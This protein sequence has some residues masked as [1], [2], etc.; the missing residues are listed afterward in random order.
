MK[1]ILSFVLLLSLLFSM[2]GS[3]FAEECTHEEVS[4]STY[5][6]TSDFVFLDE[7][8]HEMYGYEYAYDRCIACGLEM[9]ER[10]ISDEK[11]EIYSNHDFSEG[12]CRC[13]YESS[14]P[15]NSTFESYYFSNAVYFDCNEETHTVRGLKTTNIKCDECEAFL[16]SVYNEEV[17]TEVQS[18]TF[19]SG[20]CSYCD[21]T[22]EC[23]HVEY[24]SY[25]SNRLVGRE[26]IDESTHL[27]LTY[28][29]IWHQ[30]L[31][32]GYSWEDGDPSNIVER[33]DSH[34]FENGVCDC[35]FENSC[36]H[37]NY[38][39]NRSISNAKYT[40][41]N[42]L[43]HIVDGKSVMSNYCTDCYESWET[44]SEKVLEMEEHYPDYS[45]ESDY[46]TDSAMVECAHCGYNMSEAYVDLFQGLYTAYPAADVLEYINGL[47]KDFTYVDGG[48]YNNFVRY[49]YLPENVS[50][51]VIR[52]F[53][54]LRPAV[55]INEV[56]NNLFDLGALAEWEIENQYHFQ[57]EGEYDEA[58]APIDM[59]RLKSYF[60]GQWKNSRTLSSAAG[61]T[62]DR[63]GTFYAWIP[64]YYED[65]PGRILDNDIYLFL[66]IVRPGIDADYLEGKIHYA[67]EKGVRTESIF[68]ADEQAVSAFLS[69]FYDPTNLSYKESE[70]SEDYYDLSEGCQS[71]LVKQLQTT[72]VELGYLTSSADGY[73]GPDTKEAVK[74]CQREMGLSDTGVAD[75][76]FLKII[77][78]NAG[79]TA[80]LSGWLKACGY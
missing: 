29:S 20:K 36:S 30:C 53:S 72:L 57:L 59:G 6:S 13:G 17:S 33:I 40:A 42:A 12:I 7:K 31:S 5:Y 56:D 51:T 65:G 52:D 58:A 44:G 25:D 45:S 61:Y 79:E 68:V 70:E 50:D 18:H 14:C 37:E 34:Y 28:P 2:S 24:N 46:Y 10:Q 43:G 1:R 75:V 4:T 77:L 38:R 69:R 22:I 76:E 32:C 55:A 67:Y 47:N 8:Y 27:T 80:L 35:G 16:S 60:D 71:R 41:V 66:Y 11:T 54:I 63:D 26:Y 9:N 73:Y 64:V 48:V 15:H 74:A 3:C 39:S 49:G 19:Y 78:S 21:Y 23:D 62:A